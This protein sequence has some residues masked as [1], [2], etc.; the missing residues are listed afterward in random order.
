MATEA[1]PGVDLVRGGRIGA[2]VPFRG[3]TKPPQVA[4]GI[5]C[6][7]RASADHGEGNE[8]QVAPVCKSAAVRI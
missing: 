3:V 6:L 8:G 7:E 2:A 1:S 5:V 4:E